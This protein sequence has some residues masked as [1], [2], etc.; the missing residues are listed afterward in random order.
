MTRIIFPGEWNDSRQQTAAL[1]FA[2]DRDE[3]EH[4]IR[5]LLLGRVC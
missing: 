5:N 3:V 4:Q 2:E 1:W